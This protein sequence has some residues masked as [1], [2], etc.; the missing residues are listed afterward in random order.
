MS[1]IVTVEPLARH[2]TLLPLLSEW[3]IS[4]W[5][6][7]YGVGGEGNVNRDLEDFAV[8]ETLLPI[9]FVAFLNDKPV[10]A[11]ALK[12]ESIPSHKHLTPWAAAGYVL[13][14]QRGRGIGAK[15]LESMLL[16]ARSLGHTH[17]YCGTS[18]AESLL[19][20]L[21]WAAIEVTQHAGKAL[22][23]FRSAA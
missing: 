10:G 17:I 20:R 5:P 23:V 15:L 7:W 11:G 2:R 14:S 21:G 1:P 19:L 9:G 22:T 4:E 13:P 18:T 16:H 8:S 6:N 12:K 3:F